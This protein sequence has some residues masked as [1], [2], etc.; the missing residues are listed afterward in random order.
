MNS[1]AE[2]DV[3]QWAVSLELLMDD[4]IG[5]QEFTKYL[6]KEYSLEN[7]KFWLAVKD[8]KEKK[9][10]EILQVSKQI[11]DEF[12]SPGAPCE[13]N[14][15][16]KTKQKI[17]EN[18]KSPSR[19]MFDAAAEH[20]YTLLLK[21]DSYPRFIRSE[22]YK[23]LLVNGVQPLNKQSDR[24]PN[25]ITKERVVDEM[26]EFLKVP[27]RGKR[28]RHRQSTSSTQTYHSSYESSSSDDDSRSNSVTGRL[29]RSCCLG[30]KWYRGSSASR[31]PSSPQNTGGSKKLEEKNH[32][33]SSWSSLDTTVKP[34][35]TKLSKVLSLTKKCVTPMVKVM[36]VSDNVAQESQS[37][38][39]NKDIKYS[40]N[41]TVSGPSNVSVV[42]ELNVVAK[43]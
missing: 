25:G 26:C 28:E 16:G 37:V 43:K 5:L 27:K 24:S 6:Q 41:I 32:L 34:N 3:K 29:R 10:L 8:F 7:I 38:E 15:D 19:F 2:T 4:A 11:Y 9:E 36:G 23:D 12:L 17:L 14:I 31:P 1:T 30:D 21:K 20:V 35:S 42:V 13:I 18:M 22:H 33:S 39:D 40:S